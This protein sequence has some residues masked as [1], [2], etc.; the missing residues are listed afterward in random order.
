VRRWFVLS[1]EIGLRAELLIENLLQIW[2]E[3][4]TASPNSNGAWCKRIE[5]DFEFSTAFIA[6]DF[7]FGKERLDGR[8]RCQ[9]DIGGRSEPPNPGLLN[10]TRYA[11]LLRVQRPF[12]RVITG[13]ADLTTRNPYLIHR[14]HARF[15][16]VAFAR[17]KTSEKDRLSS[18][19]IA[20]T[21]L[22]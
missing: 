12:C 18:R 8:W 17:N 3:R 11:R 1:N 19:P 21:L 2:Y 7:D 9:G 14:S 13:N 6:L 22:S 16:L 5:V 10:S 4:G 20:T 15:L